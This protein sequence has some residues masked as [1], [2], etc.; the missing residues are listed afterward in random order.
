MIACIS[1]VATRIINLSMNGAAQNQSYNRLAALTDKFG[2][3]LAGSQTLEDAIGWFGVLHSHKGY[4]VFT[5]ST[6]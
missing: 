6:D 2:Y 5:M 4:I 1:D 3:R